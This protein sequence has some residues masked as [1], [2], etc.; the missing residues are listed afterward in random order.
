MLTYKVCKGT[1]SKILTLDYIPS[2]SQ[3]AREAEKLFPGFESIT[4]IVNGKEQGTLRRNS[5]PIV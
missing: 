5:N 1:D 2:S 3:L 4:S